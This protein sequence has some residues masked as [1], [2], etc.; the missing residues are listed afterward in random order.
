MHTTLGQR[1]AI[2]RKQVGLN[3]T[4]L[5]MRVGV[6]RNAVSRWENDEVVP[7]GQTLLALPAALGVSADWLFYDRP[8]GAPTSPDE[9]FARA[10]ELM[11][12]AWREKGRQ[13]LQSG[14]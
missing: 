2:A 13:G 6:E 11:E 9:A 4:E 5:G 12:W 8:S 7:D 3:Q 1:I 14:E 10:R